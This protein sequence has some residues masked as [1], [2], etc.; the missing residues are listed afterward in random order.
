MSVHRLQTIW[1]RTRKHEDVWKEHLYL[2][3]RAG[4]G[5]QAARAQCSTILQ[6]FKV[7]RKERR[8]PLSLLL[9]WAEQSKIQL[10]SQ[11]RL[12]VSKELRGR[13][14]FST[15]TLTSRGRGSQNRFVIT[16]KISQIY[17]HIFI[18]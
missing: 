8:P 5:G 2:R 3:K 6:G 17:R 16:K 12:K 15:L 10:Y 9:I 7:K 11:A 14:G 18:F 4:N 13:R 1:F